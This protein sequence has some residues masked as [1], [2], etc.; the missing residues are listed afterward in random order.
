MINRL[1]PYSKLWMFHSAKL[2]AELMEA[3]KQYINF[4]NKK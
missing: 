4:H 2:R 1:P 3:I